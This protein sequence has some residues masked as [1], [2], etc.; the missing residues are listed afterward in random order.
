M[1][2][3][4][5]EGEG[6]CSVDDDKHSYLMCHDGLCHRSCWLCRESGASI[7]AE[8]REFTLVSRVNIDSNGPT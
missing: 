6:A 5:R 3:E 1:Y 8:K 7:L 4:G 2:N